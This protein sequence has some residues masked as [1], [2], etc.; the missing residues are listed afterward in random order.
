VAGSAVVAV[1]AA[2]DPVVA[3]PAVED[4][5]VLVAVVAVV[6]VEIA[7]I[8]EVRLKARRYAPPLRTEHPA[9]ERSEAQCRARRT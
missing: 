5:A 3:V 1:L 7:Q 2:V 9:R 8:A 4:R 6:A